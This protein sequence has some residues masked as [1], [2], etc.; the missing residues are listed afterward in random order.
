MHNQDQILLHQFAT[1]SKAFLYIHLQQALIQQLSLP[2]SPENL[3]QLIA[4]IS[5][6]T[7]SG[8]IAKDVFAEMMKS[9]KSPSDIVK[10]KGLE[11]VSDDTEI[12]KLIDKVISENEDKVKDYLGGKDRLFGFFVG[13]VMKISQGKA[14]PSIVNKLLKEKLK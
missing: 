11:Q 7:I 4:L 14:N 3:G 10:E 1:I 12:L 13:Q 5:D 6:G 2:I 9:K 8:K